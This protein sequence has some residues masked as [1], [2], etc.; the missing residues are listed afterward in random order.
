MSSVNLANFSVW[1]ALIQMFGALAITG[2]ILAAITSLISRGNID[3]ARFLVAEGVLL[4]LG[5]T[6]AATLLRTIALQ[7]WNQILVFS[8]IFS[9]RTLLKKV[10]AWEK[11]KILKMTF[12][13]SIFLGSLL[14]RT[15]TS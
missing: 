7:T 14:C 12:Q 6:V 8:V 5:F 3:R 9:I 10:F 15:G 1:A 13:A 2:Y 11:T 4:S